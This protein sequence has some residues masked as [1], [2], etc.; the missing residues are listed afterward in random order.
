MYC[1]CLDKIQERVACTKARDKNA[2]ISVRPQ[3]FIFRGTALKF[4]RPRTFKLLSVTT[5]KPPIVISFNWKW[6]DTSP[7]RFWCLSNHSQPLQDLW[8]DAIGHDQTCLCVQ[9]F[10]WKT[11]W[12]SVVNFGLT[13]NKNSIRVD[14][15]TRCNTSYEW[16]L[17]SIN[18]LYM[19]RTITSPSS[20]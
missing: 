20:V 6:R 13:I 15:P 17:F 18:W 10:R 3:T 19:F 14:K 11:F 4:A 12:E 1:K 9:W 16:S 5:L 2:H 7:K 8:K